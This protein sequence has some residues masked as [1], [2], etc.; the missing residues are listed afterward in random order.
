MM[1]CLEFGVWDLFG[2]WNLG[3][4]V[5]PACLGTEQSHPRHL[6][7]I[8]Q[9]PMYSHPDHKEFDARFRRDGEIF[10]MSNRQRLAVGKVQLES[11]KRSRSRIFLRSETF[12]FV[13]R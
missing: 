10:W 12:M 3:F 8:N 5:L 7:G 2:A 11:A 9:V 1:H 4:G 6:C 13:I